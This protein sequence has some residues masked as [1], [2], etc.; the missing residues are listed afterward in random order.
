MRGVGVVEEVEHEHAV[1]L[2]VRPVEAR[3]GLRR[4]DAGQ[5]LVHVHGVQQ[6]L[7][8]AGLELVRAHQE[9]VAI[10]LEPLGDLPRGQAVQRRFAYLRAAVLVLAGEGDQRLVAALALPQVAADGMVVLDRAFDAGGR[11]QSPAPKISS[12]LFLGVAVNAKQLALGSSLRDSIR[13]LI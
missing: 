6:R 11:H 12:V 3:Q 2:G 13:R 4:L 7:V 5:R 9:A 8:V 1:L 10:L